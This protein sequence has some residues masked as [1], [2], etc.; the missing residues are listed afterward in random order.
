[1]Q[2]KNLTWWIIGIAILIAIGIGIYFL[3]SG[4]GSSVTNTAGSIP[5]PPALP[6]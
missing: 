5:S 6:S 2:N 4:D 3:F 1:M